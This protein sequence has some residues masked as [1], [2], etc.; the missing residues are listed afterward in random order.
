MRIPNRNDES[1]Q[2]ILP[3]M[4]ILHVVNKPPSTKDE[5]RQILEPMSDVVKERLDRLMTIIHE[6]A[7]VTDSESIM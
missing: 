6:C 5:L 4:R 2:Y 7:N 3:L 1:V